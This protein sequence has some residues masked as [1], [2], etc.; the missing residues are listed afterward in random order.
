MFQTLLRKENLG[1]GLAVALTGMSALPAQAQLVNGSTFT[2]FLECNNDGSALIVGSNA[3]V[4][5]WQYASD[6]RHENTDGH[7]Y[8]IAGMSLKQT[9]DEL[10]VVINGNTPLMGTGYDRQANQVVWGDLFFT[11]SNYDSFQ[12]ATQAGDVYGIHF[13]GN[14]EAKVNELGV[15]R[16]VV[17]T[18]VG[19]N[20][21]GHNT[22]GNYMDLVDTD[23]DNFFGDIQTEDTK[24]NNSYLDTDGFGV[25]V[26]GQ[27]DKVYGDG[28]EMLSLDDDR[29]ADFD[30]NN[31]A[32]AGDETIAFKINL[33]ALQYQPPIREQ[34]A[35]LGI[36]WIWDDE[37]TAIEDELAVVEQTIT[38]LQAEINPR[39]KANRDIRNATPGFKEVSQRNSAANKLKNYNKDLEKFETLV[40]SLEEKKAVWDA[41]TPD[42]QAAADPALVWTRKD[43]EDLAYQTTENIPDIQAKIQAIQDAY[44]ETELA[45]AKQDYKDMLNQIRANNTEVDSNGEDYVARE[46]KLKALNSEKK[47]QSTLKNNL[48]EDYAQLDADIRKLLAD[49]R[50]ALIDSRIAAAEEDA[51]AASALET[52]TGGPRTSADGGIPETRA[53][54][55]AKLDPNGEAVSVSEPTSILGLLAMV[56][57]GATTLKR[58]KQNA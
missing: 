9:A 5:G 38:E 22:Y 26:I 35:D 36:E 15:Y 40:T 17:G 29:L 24:G 19:V 12:E 28:F 49:T 48:K 31:F 55:R 47:A 23:V 10:Y 2:L 45:T 39:N 51:A 6:A 8:D 1:L 30:V 33:S 43:A 11:D 27:G 42:E 7:Y 34:A 3:I 21:F 46:Q 44:T 14:N 32:E 20:N 25:N 54:L 4:D 37:F 53:E 57:I 52:E 41:M 16:N 58:E 56:G 50:Q 13:A 18:G